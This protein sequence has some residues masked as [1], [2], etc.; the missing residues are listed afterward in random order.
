ERLVRRALAM[1]GTCTGEHGIGLG[2]QQFLVE[3]AGEGAVAL[4]RQI[5]ATLD[6]RNILNPGK[7]FPSLPQESRP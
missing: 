4:M 3:E 5:K 1:G 6:P 7:I 2:K